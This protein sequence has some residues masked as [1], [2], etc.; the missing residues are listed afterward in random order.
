ME[1]IDLRGKEEQYYMDGL[2]LNQEAYEIVNTD[3]NE[4][5]VDTVFEICEEEQ[6]L[7]FLAWILNL[8]EQELT[9]GKDFLITHNTSFRVLWN[10]CSYLNTYTVVL[11]EYYVDRVY[12][13]SY[14]FYYSSKHFSYNRFCRRLSLFQGTL[15]SNFFDCT[16]EELEKRFVGTIVIR[17]IPERS[18][19][20]TL[21]NPYYFLPEN[22]VCRIRVTNYNVT[23][24]GKRLSVQAF[25]YSM[26]DGET[27]SCAEITI[28]NL[29][30]YY[31]QSYPEYHY[32]LPSEISGLVEKN[33]F[34]RRLPTNGLSYEL[35][36]K[37]FCDAG[38]YPRL[39]SAKKMTNIKFRHVLHYYIESG[40]PV[41]LG[42]K[43]GEE[44][45]HS[46]IGIG[47]KI[48]ENNV[49]GGEFT[50]A[51]DSESKN[52]LWTCDTADIVDTYCLMDDNQVPYK[53]SKCGEV[54]RERMDLRLNDCEVEYIMVPLYKRMILE[55]ADAYDICLSILA[56]QRL[57][58]KDLL[59]DID[60]SPELIK[61]DTN[62]D[63]IGTKE[64]PLVIRLFM[65][66]SRTFRRKRDEEFQCG[67]CE[68][69]DLYNMTVFPKFIWVCELATKTLYQKNQVLGEIIIDAT[70]SADAKMDSFII[71]HYPNVICRRMPDDFNE[72][73]DAKFEK[74]DKWQP[75][76]S[77]RGN[78]FEYDK[79]N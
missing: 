7:N 73:E 3:D 52:V 41:A 27:T 45:K 37:I 74:I 22:I 54:L 64:E 47:Y 25:P 67:N 20:R 33:S 42:L 57:G 15:K 36:S 53:I 49:L 43:L 46:V 29:L 12:R 28:L 32:L 66:S 17:P 76:P 51:Y 31:S 44:N 24:Y 75:F 48:P 8:S 63:C 77:F 35:I 18:I 59:K 23:V 4:D 60:I 71:I 69:R 55:A 34:E 38:F 78:L 9:R 11:E 21:L 39:Y 68:V 16:S 6:Q 30:D 56:S 40:I 13:D 58:I 50:C 79:N 2:Y 72:T 5:T 14:Y 70:S 1:C 62:V 65:A 26:Q 19:G 10:L 61:I